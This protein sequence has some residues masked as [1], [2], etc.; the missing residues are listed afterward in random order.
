MERYGKEKKDCSG[1]ITVKV[2]SILSRIV[3]KLKKVIFFPHQKRRLVPPIGYISSNSIRDGSLHVRPLTTHHPASCTETV[4]AGKRFSQD[5]NLLSFKKSCSYNLR[6]HGRSSDH[7]FDPK[8]DLKQ[9]A[10]F[11]SLSPTARYAQE[12]LA[13]HSVYRALFPRRS[14]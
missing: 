8:V 5:T 10:S 6:T 12:K 1:R 7:R 9:M 11:F 13:D 4:C 14:N 2:K 3:I